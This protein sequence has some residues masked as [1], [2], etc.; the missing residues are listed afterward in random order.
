MPV[1]GECLD[2]EGAAKDGPEGVESHFA[3]AVVGDWV[4]DHHAE[5]LAEGLHGAPEG[6]VL[7]VEAV[8]PAGVAEAE[9][10]YETL[11]GNDVSCDSSCQSKSA[12]ETRRE[13]SWGCRACR[14][15]AYTRTKSSTA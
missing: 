11:V 10:V 9:V 8:Y 14:K 13:C 5:E 3:A 4:E 12:N 6:D 7:R 15:S 2:D 1:S